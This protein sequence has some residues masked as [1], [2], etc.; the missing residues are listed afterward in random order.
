[1]NTKIL[2]YL[3]LILSCLL[4]SCS[5]DYRSAI[6]KGSTMLMSIDVTDKEVGS[7]FTVLSDYLMIKDPRACGLDLRDKLYL[8]QTSESKFG[9]CANVYN[10]EDL[11]DVFAKLKKKGKATEGPVRLRSTFYILSGKIVC[12]YNDDALVVMGP[13]TPSAQKETIQYIANLLKQKEEDSMLGSLLIKKLESLK[14][15][16]SLVAQASALPQ[17]FAS[18]VS[19]G[20]PKD[21]KSSE[22]IIA[23][24]VSIHDETILIDSEPFSFNEHINSE[25]QRN[26]SV[27]RPITNKYTSSLGNKAVMGL[28]ANFEGKNLLPVIKKSDVLNSLFSGINTLIDIDAIINNIDGDVLLS[29]PSYVESG[30]EM[31]LAGQLANTNFIK[32]VDNLNKLVPSASIL[33]PWNND[34]YCLNNK[35]IP[36]YFGVTHGKNPQLY[37]GSSAEVA[38]NSVKPASSPIAPNVQKLIEGKRLGLYLS[39]S[40]IL[41]EKAGIGMMMI[42]RMIKI[43]SVVYTVK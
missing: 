29:A 36:L 35:E 21:A 3:V 6:P 32:D 39:A 34:G 23:A 10:S 14:S 31:S 41:P 15:P 19:I 9:L 25:L 5:K 33:S 22:C 7:R 13:V 26:Y 37:S 42:P 2:S 27:L 40:S 11:H 1:M 43:K 38:L 30:I 4:T 20:L 8:F 24:N 12:G 18:F 28:F 16:I 17:K